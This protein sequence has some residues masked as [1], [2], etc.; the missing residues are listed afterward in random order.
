M[1]NLPAPQEILDK[2]Q[3]L[4]NLAAK[5]PSAEE[6]ASA[7]SK[8]QELLTKYN[9]DAAV[10]ER[11]AGTKSDRREDLRLRGGFYEYQ[12]TLW[13]AVAQLNFCIYWCQPYRDRT[14]GRKLPDGSRVG[15]QT[16]RHRLVGRLVNTTAS[17]IMAEYLETSIEKGLRERLGGDHRQLYSNWA[18]SYREGAVSRLVEKIR[19]RYWERREADEKAKPVMK[20]GMSQALTIS[21]YQDAEYDANI[22]FVYG[23]GTSAKWAADRAARAAEAK[24]EEEAYTAW[25][26]ANPEEAKKKEA[27]ERE[28]RRKAASRYR[29]GRSER[30]QDLNAYDHGRNAAE[31]ISLDQ[32]MDSGSKKG[33]T[34]E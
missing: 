31:N 32:Q 15:K 28:K 3:K 2:I 34:H 24:A 4:L 21:M 1:S 7:T 9:L 22:D 6:A 13:R 14:R 33:L 30:H 5:N 16:K 19:A 25:A 8:A 20:E 27:E 26:A 18:I 12:Q 23:E 11:H 10:V 29:G 17:R